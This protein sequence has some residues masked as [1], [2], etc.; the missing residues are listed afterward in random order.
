MNQDSIFTLVLAAAI[1]EEL[2]RSA[3]SIGWTAGRPCCNTVCRS[4][5]LG[6]AGRSICSGLRT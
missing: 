4:G 2:S 6:W 1:I 5:S 3:C